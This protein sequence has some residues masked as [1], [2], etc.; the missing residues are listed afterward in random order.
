MN[1]RCITILNLLL[2]KDGYTSLQDIAAEMNVSK[3]SIYYDICKINEW[4][5]IHHIPELEIIRGK[6]IR[7]DQVDKD[8]IEELMDVSGGEGYIFLPSERVK[9]IICCIIHNRLP[10]YVEQLMSYC[11]VS[12]NT[13]FGDLRVVVN[14]LQEHGLS[15]EYVSKEGYTVAGDTVRIRALYFLF[16]ND[17]RPLFEG[18]LLEFTNQEEIERYYK[19]LKIIEKELKTDYV[20]GSLLSLAAL[21]P[22]MY[23]N[24]STLHLTDIKEEAITATKEFDLVGTYFPD[25]DIKEKQYLCLHLLGSR[26]NFTSEDFFDA[27]AN[28]SVYELTKA[29]I[30]EFEKKVCVHFEEREEL[31]RSLFVHINTSQYRYQYGIQIGDPIS[32]DIMREYPDLFDITK[33]VVKYLEYMIGLPIPD[34]EVAYLALHFGAHLKVSEPEADA[35]RVLIVCANGISTGK[36]LQ[37]EIQRL[38]PFFQIVGVIA[39]IEARNAQDVCDI[40]ISTVRIR[41]V[42]PV[43]VVHPVLTAEDRKHILNHRLIAGRYQGRIEDSIFNAVKKYAKKEE[44]EKLKQDIINCIFGE[45]DQHAE[46]ARGP[47][48][49]LTDYL[50]VSK[51]QVTEQEFTWQDGIRFAGKCLVDNGSIGTEYLEAIIEHVLCYG[52]YMFLSEEVMLAHAKP[53]DGVRRLDVAVTIFKTPVVFP[54]AK[55]GRVLFVLA[56]RNQE[57]HLKILNDILKMARGKENVDAICKAKSKEE[58]L[59]WLQSNL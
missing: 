1:D 42:V 5:V 49:G 8:R 58:I 37:R 25:L 13:V 22:I 47:V 33:A 40:I 35:L 19:R 17:L 53:E 26:V 54:K 30:T 16:F 48:G 15:L 34:S 6:G 46:D 20:D 28:E 18:G 3:R 56:A 50:T 52:N 11:Q 44:H 43:I 27:R 2:Q 38:L 4:M 57:K 23:Q 45:E 29:L 39:A 36:M 55:K 10:V 21:L 24:G 59:I 12:R 32:M 14:Q 31:E 9:I 51:I 7:I 41:S